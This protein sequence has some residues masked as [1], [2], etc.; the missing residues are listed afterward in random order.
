MSQE[1]V[2]S[3]FRPNEKRDKLAHDL[4]VYY[5]TK[6]ESGERH[7]A[8]RRWRELDSKSRDHWRGMAQVSI[9]WAQSLLSI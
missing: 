7:F 6:G 1:E 8:E 3:G 2:A 9:A 4:Y 5:Q